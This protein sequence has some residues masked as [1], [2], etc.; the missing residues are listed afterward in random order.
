MLDGEFILQELAIERIYYWS[1][2]QHF[3][4]HPADLE[5][6]I[7]LARTLHNPHA[8]ATTGVDL[9]IPAI[10]AYLAK[11]RLI[12]QGTERVDIG[13]WQGQYSHPISVRLSPLHIKVVGSDKM[14]L[15][16][17]WQSQKCLAVWID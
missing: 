8:T 14:T 17:F 2:E 10:M 9:Q 16:K 4:R 12:L 15:E 6:L 1:Y 3:I 11:Q 7:Q 13:T 5:E